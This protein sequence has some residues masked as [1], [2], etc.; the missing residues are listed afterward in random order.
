M[1]DIQRIAKNIECVYKVKLF[2]HAI[3]TGNVLLSKPSK[4]RV[5]QRLPPLKR[6]EYELILK[7]QIPHNVKKRLRVLNL[8]PSVFLCFALLRLGN[9]RAVKSNN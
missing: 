6:S 5:Y 1:Q 7:R 2:T 9:G 4:I 8:C 3:R